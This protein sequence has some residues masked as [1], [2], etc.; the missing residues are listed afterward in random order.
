MCVWTNKPFITF[1]LIKK[2][3]K[4]DELRNIKVTS[5]YIGLIT[6]CFM[7]QVRYNCPRKLYIYIY[8][9]VCVCVCVW[10]CNQHFLN[11]FPKKLSVYVITMRSQFLLPFGIVNMATIIVVEYVPKKGCKLTLWKQSLKNPQRKLLLLK[12][13]LLKDRKKMKLRVTGK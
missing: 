7:C 3:S 10:Y 5:F 12:F 2:C 9:Y 8:I 6:K 13:A 1:L 4:A 11:C